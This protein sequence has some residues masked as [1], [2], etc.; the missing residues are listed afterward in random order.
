[1]P[2]TQRGPPTP[3]VEEI[4]HFGVFVNVN[5]PRLKI[6]LREPLGPSQPPTSTSGGAPPTQDA[7]VQL[8]PELHLEVAHPSSHARLVGTHAR[9]SQEQDGNYALN[10]TQKFRIEPTMEALHELLNNPLTLELHDTPTSALLA[11]AVLDL[12]PFG[13]GEQAISVAELPMAIDGAAAEAA[14]AAAIAAATRPA[15]Q[16]KRVPSG[17]GTR[18]PANQMLPRLASPPK[19][20]GL[21]VALTHREA[22]RGASPEALVAAA[23]SPPSLTSSAEGP[24]T[25]RAGPPKPGGGKAGGKG[26]GEQQ[27][28]VIDESLLPPLEPFRYLP[29]GVSEPSALN[30][31][32]FSVDGPSKNLPPGLLGAHDAAGG[33][34]SFMAGL[35]LPTPCPPMVLQGGVVQKEDTEQTDNAHITWPHKGRLRQVLKPEA[36]QAILEYLDREGELRV[37]VARYVEPDK[38]LLGDSEAAWHA[39]HGLAVL[40]DADVLLE[41]GTNKIGKDGVT[42]ARLSAWEASQHHEATLP[43]VLPA[44]TTPPGKFKPVEEVNFGQPLSGH[45][46]KLSK[47]PSTKQDPSP[48]AD[49]SSKAILWNS[50]TYSA[51]ESCGTTINVGIQFARNLLPAWEPPAAPAKKLQDFIPQRDLNPPPP[52]VTC[53]DDFKAQVSTVLSQL[54]A[55]YLDVSAKHDQGQVD[56]AASPL[57]ANKKLVKSLNKSGQYMAMRNG[58]KAA[59]VRTVQERFQHSG[60][61][62]PNE[63]SETY[64]PLY[65]HLVGIAHS[66]VNKAA[67]DSPA[68][69]PSPEPAPPPGELAKLALQALEAEA[70]GDARRSAALMRRR[71]LDLNNAQVHVEAAALASRS[72]D[73]AYALSLLHTAIEI[74]PSHQHALAAASMLHLDAAIAAAAGSNTSGGAYPGAGEGTV[75]GDAYTHWTASLACADALLGA[76]QG[77]SKGWVTLALV[78]KNSSVA[79]TPAGVKDSSLG[80]GANGARPFSGPGEDGNYGRCIAELEAQVT[81]SMQGTAAESSTE[82]QQLCDQ[83]NAQRKMAGGAGSKRHAEQRKELYAEQSAASQGV[84]E[85][86]QE[87]HSREQGG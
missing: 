37:E 46:R 43:S 33:R 53:D 65:S 5:V 51:W 11:T 45:E 14:E 81:A 72:G 34:L 9:V 12:L 44:Y 58:L 30:V 78:H 55:A 74:S 15:S 54:A 48:P 67:D 40:S 68:P 38:A 71:L 49:G 69:L 56:P 18:N 8:W 41:G 66:V 20:A 21:S 75:V 10:F 4:G 63:M 62:S 16:S 31:L 27:E 70:A 80:A 77:S 82:G 39:Y 1:M 35:T 36:A 24:L 84:Q 25:A 42:E 2:A 19:L 17:R 57:E 3:Q 79:G 83:V 28:L 6:E 87:A 86:V 64:G 29:E 22:P 13:L 32:E 61:M 85:G 23:A 7:S 52:P 50:P 59:I 60:S 47:Q 76:T 73:H 26:A